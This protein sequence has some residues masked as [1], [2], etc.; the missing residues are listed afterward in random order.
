MGYKIW[1]ITTCLEAKIGKKIFSVLSV[2]R[3]E[4]MGRRSGQSMFRLVLLK[5]KGDKFFFSN[6]LAILAK[7]HIIYENFLSLLINF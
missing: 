7:R 1:S 6:F 5:T 4:A 2:E 3:E